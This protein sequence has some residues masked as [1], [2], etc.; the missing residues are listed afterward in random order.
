MNIDIKKVIAGFVAINTVL[1]L[2]L[3]P[4]VGMV[5]V[6]LL[7][8]GGGYVYF[9][10]KNKETMTQDSKEL[11][12]Y[13]KTIR[14]TRSMPIVKDTGLKLQKGEQVFL[15]EKVLLLNM[16]SKEFD[17]PHSE[18]AKKHHP[19][20]PGFIEQDKGS[21][22]LTNLNVVFRGEDLNMDLPLNVPIDFYSQS[23]LLFISSGN[24]RGN[25]VAFNVKNPEIWKE[26]VRVIQNVK[27]PISMTMKDLDFLNLENN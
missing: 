14:S 7:M 25:T 26:A 10:R 6:V 12:K 19:R 4:I 27:D 2:I 17:M 21:I 18:A 11:E 1:I 9:N 20:F 15:F 24:K 8:A 16:A 22:A 5:L 23:N 3:N 13:I